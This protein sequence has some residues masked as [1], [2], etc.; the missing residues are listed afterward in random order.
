MNSSPKS[1]QRLAAASRPRGQEAPGEAAPAEPIPWL[2]GFPEQVHT[3]FVQL[4]WKRWA[5]A[6]ILASLVLLAVL[7]L[8]QTPGGT[9][10]SAPPSPRIPVPVA[11]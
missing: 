5:A 1:W 6:A 4:A 7:L 3:V 8:K 9:A 2:S 11:P 10:E